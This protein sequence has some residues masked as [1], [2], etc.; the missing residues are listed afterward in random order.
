MFMEVL[1]RNKE[2]FQNFEG[3]NRHCTTPYRCEMTH[4]K[5]KHNY[6]TLPNNVI[7]HR[8]S[9]KMAGYIHSNLKNAV[10]L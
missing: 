7:L 6:V 3:P 10:Y 9:K 5:N 1:C 8:H 2:L 4:Y